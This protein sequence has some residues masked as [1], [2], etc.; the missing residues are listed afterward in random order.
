[1]DFSIDWSESAVF[2]L[3]QIVRYVAEDDPFAATKLGEGII[4]A[5]TKIGAFP[6]SGRVV[7]EEGDDAL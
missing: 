6:R 5:V 7:P 2:D 1:M 4:E 3:E